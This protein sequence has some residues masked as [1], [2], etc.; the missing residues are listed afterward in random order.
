MKF[1]RTT[2]SFLRSGCQAAATFAALTLA[3]R[4]VADASPSATTLWQ[5][6]LQTP[7]THSN[8]P[9][10][11]YSDYHYGE[12]PIPDITGPVFN[13][14]EHGAAGDGETNDFAA[15]RAAL[16]AADAAGGGVVWFPKGRYRTDGVL[17][18]HSNNTVLRGEDRDATEIIF[19]R[20]LATAHGRNELDEKRHRSRWSWQGGL[21]WFAPHGRDTWRAGNSPLA[22]GASES[23]AH[24]ELG[25][26]GKIAAPAR[27]GDRRLTLGNAAAPP[28]LKR[29]DFVLL[30]IAQPA[31]LSLLKHLAGDGAWA[32]AYNWHQNNPAGYPDGKLPGPLRWIVEIADIAGPEITLRQPL[33]FDIRDGWDARLLALGPAI[34]ESG[35]ENL[36]LRFLR[37]YVY[38]DARHHNQEPGWNA[39]WFVKAI[40]CWLRDVTL[41]D[42]DNG[43]GVASSKCVTL[44]RFLITSSRP[45][46]ERHHHGTT[47]R[48]ASSDCLFSD[49]EIRSRPL[50][51][52]NVEQFS[53]G[54]VWTR[55]LMRHGTF[56]THR[57]M[58]FDN[59]RTE[60]TIRNDGRHGGVGGPLMGAR[61]VNWNIRVTNNEP[62]LIAWA[63]HMPAGALVGLHGVNPRWDIRPE[64]APTGE[65]SATR[66]ESQGA[67]PSPPNLYEAQLRHRLATAGAATTTRIP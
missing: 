49:F 23:W 54:N 52:I 57:N 47:C 15:I 48:S 41:I 59:V 63:N 43:P 62:Y 19:T 9:G 42:P 38:D 37:D 65:I 7:D 66:V 53:C 25:F 26:R 50:H 2:L 31:D 33:R 22:R 13:V 8:I 11:S 40:N 46:R 17:F 61:F 12:R 64:N 1:P 67:L 34:R 58:P 60:I 35:I 27:R 44:A 21:V 32:D 45:E 4:A 3:V 6:Y 36:T 24:A 39:P 5:Q 14:R 20:S 18:V 10:V 51:G 55:G 56:D 29:G 16:Q 28:S 30:Q